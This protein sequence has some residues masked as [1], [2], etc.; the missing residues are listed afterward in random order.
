MST[1]SVQ[2]YSRLTYPALEDVDLTRVNIHEQAR[3]HATGYAAGLRAAVAETE[4][5]RAR[6][7]AEHEAALEAGRENIRATLQV[8]NRA[9]RS[10]EQAAVPVAEEVQDSLAAAA[11]ELAEAL[12]GQELDD[13]ETSARA[14]LTR[15]LHGVSR[16]EVRAVRLHPDDLAA[17]DLETISSADVRLK[18]DRSLNR[19]DAMT[20]FAHG[21]LDATLASA[22][23][24]AR[25]ALLGRTA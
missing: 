10:L 12:L 1:E 23:E 17:L 20:D 13:A 3:G 14:A 21:Y 18:A 25:T 16:E 5:L 22:M 9:V 6:L 7:R 15:A 19:G 8:L 11:I 2:A 24:R 4:Q